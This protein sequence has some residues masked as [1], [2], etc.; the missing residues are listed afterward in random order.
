M[1]GPGKYDGAATAAR[2]DTQALGVILIVFQGKDGHGFSAQLPPEIL[3]TVPA[4]LRNVADQIERSAI[5]RT[6]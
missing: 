1:M 6:A 3:L 4:I 5:G 2:E